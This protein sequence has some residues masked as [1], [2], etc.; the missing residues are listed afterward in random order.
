ML[1][2]ATF[3]MNLVCDNC[4]KKA[5]YHFGTQQ[6]V[7]LTF[8]IRK[9]MR[10]SYTS[11]SDVFGIIGV[12]YLNTKRQKKIRQRLNRADSVKKN[13]TKQNIF[14]AERP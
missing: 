10:K 4:E 14:S 5:W 1:Q 12:V 7:Q 3:K 8:N 11:L 2:F 9:N 13:K 6:K